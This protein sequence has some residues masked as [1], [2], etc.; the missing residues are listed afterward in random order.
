MLLRSVT[1]SIERIS[2]DG[3]VLYNARNNDSRGLSGWQDASCEMWISA[4]SFFSCEE[5]VGGDQRAGLPG[6]AMA[7][8]PLRVWIQ[9]YEER[10]LTSVTEADVGISIS[11]RSRQ[12]I[13]VMIVDA[14]SEA[15]VL[16][17]ILS[18][19]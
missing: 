13:S 7:G 9:L 16:K 14:M 10:C 5:V 8:D 1:T 11:R 2:N 4:E 3:W 19:F 17:M 12:D 6:T 15:V 18:Y